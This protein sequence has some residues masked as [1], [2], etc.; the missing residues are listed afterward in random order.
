MKPSPK[1]S[2]LSRGTSPSPSHLQGNPRERGRRSPFFNPVT[3]LCVWL[4]VVAPGFSAEPGEWKAGVAKV[5]ITP[6]EP[7]WMA[8]YAARTGPSDGVLVDLYARVLALGDAGSS[9]LIIVTLDLIEIPDALRESIL[10][11]AREKHGQILGRT[12]EEGG[13]RAKRTGPG[14]CGRGRPGC[15]PGPTECDVV[16]QPSRSGAPADKAR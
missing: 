7:V 11:V 15:G 3:L 5:S 4:T 9:R 16:H 6:T 2:A 13:C 1:R 10:G 12:G 8:G 14:L